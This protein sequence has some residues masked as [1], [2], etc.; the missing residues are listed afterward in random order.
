MAARRAWPDVE[1]IG[2]DRPDVLATDPVASLLSRAFSNPSDVRHAD[3]VILATPVAQIVQLLAQHADDLRDASLV[4]DT[5]STK[6]TILATAESAGL[7]NFVGGHPMSGA[8]SSGPGAA[9]ADLFDRRYWF[10]VAQP[11]T[12]AFAAAQNFV[13]ALGAEAI[14]W[15][16]DGTQ[17]DQ[18]MAAVSH[19]PQVVASALLARIGELAG[20]SYLPLAGQGLLDTTRLAAS[21]ASM[22]QSVLASN[23]DLLR[24]L[25]Q[26]LARDLHGFAERLDD[27][28]A[29][30]RLFDTANHWRRVL[31]RATQP[32]VTEVAK[33]TAHKKANDV[34]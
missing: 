11:G 24:P 6:R 9:R 33:A 14:W 27:A 34:A 4:L 23:A 28:D 30:R 12:P 17:H 31:E 18:A 8:E 29:V 15:D 5:G 3:V 25:M 32:Q 22:W 2:V 13:S 20:D 16:D 1:I 21:S 26:H 10:L 7:R 19:L